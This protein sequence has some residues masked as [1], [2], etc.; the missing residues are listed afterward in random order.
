[1]VGLTDERWGLMRSIRT[2]LALMLLLGCSACAPLISKYDPI[3]YSKAVDL[4][5]ESLSL[6]AKATEPYDQHKPEAEALTM[7]LQKAYEYAQGRP[8]N[9]ISAQ[10][11]Q[12]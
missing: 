3:A 12:I 8:D 2:T 11:W 1:M 6:E 4:K 9:S 10:Q 7:N 5:V